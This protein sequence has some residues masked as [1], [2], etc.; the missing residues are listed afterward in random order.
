MFSAEGF[1]VYRLGFIFLEM[2]LACLFR[3]S[4]ISTSNVSVYF[5]GVKP[6]YCTYLKSERFYAAINDCGKANFKPCATDSL[7]RHI[8]SPG[9]S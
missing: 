6:L 2:A 8:R 5:F 3:T 7:F 1:H 9:L 4:S